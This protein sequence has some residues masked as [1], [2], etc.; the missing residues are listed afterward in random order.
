MD[1]VWIEKYRPK[2]L[3]E[4]T[5][6]DDVVE[7]LKAYV[8]THSLPHL[9]FAGPAGT[10]KTTC[11]LALAKE[12]FGEGWKQNFQ[13]M[14]ASD[15]R[16]IQVVR[17]KIKDFAR[18]A[19]IGET[20]FKII[21][22]DEADALTPEAQ[23]ALRRTMEKFTKTCR[24]ILSCVTPDTK[25]LLPEEIEITMDDFMKNFETKT[26]NK[27]QNFKGKLSKD[28]IVLASIK[29]DPKTIGK[30]T[31]EITTMTG[32]KLK[33]TED[34]KL[35]TSKGW[36]AAG[37]ITK[38]DKLLV[39]PHLEGTYFEN[40]NNKII[41]IED[42]I[43]FLTKREE[44]EGFKS[45]E[46]AERY[47][48]LKTIEKNKI[49][50]RIKE[51]NS[52]I[53]TNKGLTK[54]EKE[55][56]DVIKRNTKI[57][58]FEIQKLIGLS[59]IRTDQLLKSIEN[60]GYILRYVGKNKTHYFV[61]SNTKAVV[62]RN[63]MDIKK[64]IEKEFSIQVAYS[65]IKKALSEEIMH[66]NVDR[67]IGELKR[68]NL[69]D[70]TY[71]NSRQTGALARIVAFML[72]DGH[73]VKNDIRLYFSG[74]RNAL[75]NVKKDLRTLGYNNFS[76]T[77]DKEI[78]GE[79]RGKRFRGVSTSFYLDSRTLSLFLQYL[80][81]PNGDKVSTVYNVPN[82]V[83]KGTKFVKREFLRSLFGCEGDKP[84]CKKYNF[85][86]INLRQNKIKNLKNNMIEFYNELRELL[87]V[88]EVSSYISIRDEKEKRKKDSQDVLT[89]ALTLKSSNENLYRFFA[90][91]GYAYEEYKS[92]LSRL[93]SEYLKHKLFTIELW[94]RKSLLIETEIGKGISQRN[95]ARLVDCSHDFVAAQ[96]KGK[97]VHLPRKNFVEFDRWIDKYENDCFIENKIIEIKEIKCDDV[98]DITCSQD[99]NFI[100][101]GFISH[102]C[103]YSSKIIE[104]IQSRCAVF[105]FRPLK[106]E[107]IKKYL[108]F[109][110]KN[111]GLKIEE[112]GADAIIYVASGDMRKAVSALQVAASVSEKIDAENIYRITATAKPEDVKRMLN[113]AIEGDFIKARNCL[114][115]MLINY[116]LS[117]EDIIK[118]IHKTIFDLSIPDEKKIE[119][120]DK[121]GEVEFRM[122]EGSN[123]RIQLE[124][125]LAHFMLAGKKT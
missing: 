25:I 21:F 14:N 115:E 119:L 117:G 111:E 113:T 120:I 75:E 76:E 42:F 69:L 17:T 73:I 80:G 82:F 70:L 5:G 84:A 7:R 81:V 77:S 98:R 41:D 12:M 57:S 104:P 74:N 102:N 60:K 100:S 6:Q 10:G 89:F 64:I 122:V 106:Q 125:L 114:D 97:D 83:K 29:L 23:A 19:P 26:L 124:S 56:Y 2:K 4:V 63:L 20:N 85:N 35:L 39:Y 9:L 47:G 11:A 30:K 68:K 34:H 92:R 72:G 67:V 46:A 91:I 16:G 112:D 45:I 27:V 51:L 50:N 32:R 53:K 15:E 38:E 49:I 121:T 103:N 3:D 101:N 24:F 43:R 96:L 48:K 55:I 44:K 109:I 79:I 94:K 110:A 54:R 105:R 123:E 1:D 58:R 116:G 13:E 36:K 28:D 52:V 18:T 66:G 90:R 71:Y 37:E 8:K 86:A 40:N 62:L 93:A 65:S 88:F 118:Q 31:L 87:N 78:Y 22:L 59:R 107:D 99:H 95:V 61:T 33:L 108:N